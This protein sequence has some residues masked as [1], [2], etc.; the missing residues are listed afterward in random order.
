MIKTELDSF[1]DSEMRQLNSILK[2]V[3]HNDLVRAT[4]RNLT[5]SNLEEWKKQISEFVSQLDLLEREKKDLFRGSTLESFTGID[6][7]I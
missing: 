4:G 7:F 5:E 2:N 3:S 1:S 6:Y